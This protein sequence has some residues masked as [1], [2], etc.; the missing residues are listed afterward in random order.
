MAQA[1]TSITPGFFSL[2]QLHA[3]ATKLNREGIAVN[4]P[5]LMGSMEQG[6]AH[7]DLNTAVAAPARNGRPKTIGAAGWR[8]ETEEAGASIRSNQNRYSPSAA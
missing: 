3:R 4:A 2:R 5:D 8:D 6:R 7:R 1:Q